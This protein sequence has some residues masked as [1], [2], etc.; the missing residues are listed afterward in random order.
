MG[1]DRG[2]A[3]NFVYAG[4]PLINLCG[5]FGGGERDISRRPTVASKQA[6][7]CFSSFRLSASQNNGHYKNTVRV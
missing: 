4:S 1:G 3:Y 2:A 5:S 6:T 7:M